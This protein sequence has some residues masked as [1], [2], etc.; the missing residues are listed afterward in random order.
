M[1]F[2]FTGS[3]TYYASAIRGKQDVKMALLEFGGKP[4]REFL[5]NQVHFTVTYKRASKINEEKNPM[6]MLNLF[7]F[8]LS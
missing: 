4:T 1:N 2:A 5:M 7:S 8:V 3:F 6:E